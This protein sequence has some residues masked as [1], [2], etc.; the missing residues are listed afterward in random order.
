MEQ[1]KERVAVI[2][3]H[4]KTPAQAVAAVSLE[5]AAVALIDADT[6]ADYR[7]AAQLIAAQGRPISIA[8]ISEGDDPK[9]ASVPTLLVRQGQ[10]VAAAKLAAGISK[11]ADVIIA[12]VRDARKE[13]R[14]VAPT[15]AEVV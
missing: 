12:H 10:T 9:P 14:H 5:S 3:V 6:K 11:D 7:A 1:T 4:G 8:P 13:V 2:D 15:R